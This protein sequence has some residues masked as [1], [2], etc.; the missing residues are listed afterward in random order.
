MPNV[1]GRR[2]EQRPVMDAATRAEERRAAWY[3]AHA[4]GYDRRHPGLPGDA[5][6]YAALAGGRRVLEIGC[7]TGRL[8]RDLLGTA[9]QVVALDRS[10]AMIGEA[11]AALADAGCGRL[12]LADAPF[13]PFRRTF[14]LVLLTYRTVQ[15]LSPDRRRQ[16]WPAVRDVL[17]EGGAVA[18]DTWHGRP[19]GG[20]QASDVAVE[21]LTREELRADLKAAG[22]RLVRDAPFPPLA[23][24]D[25]LSR[26][27]IAAREEACA[28]V[29][30]FHELLDT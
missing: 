2:T 17:R 5:A 16:L 22:F 4:A 12:L 21:P 30:T 25:S 26:V 19:A 29:E 23:G 15:H 1:L 10:A 14:E 9:T 28:I 20:R 18:F 7:G 24:D 11:R 13:L 3:E 27:W 8:V 6:F